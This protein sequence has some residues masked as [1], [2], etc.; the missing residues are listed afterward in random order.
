MAVDLNEVQAMI[1]EIKKENERLKEEVAKRDKE[2]AGI[3][4]TTADMRLTIKEVE[5]YLDIIQAERRESYLF[6]IKDEFLYKQ[7]KIRA[8]E[9]FGADGDTGVKWR[10]FMEVLLKAAMSVHW[11]V[12]KARWFKTERLDGNTEVGNG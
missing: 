12:I 11:T 6:N 5:P 10:T 8:R 4:K 3:K 1:E 2:I 7:L 9:V